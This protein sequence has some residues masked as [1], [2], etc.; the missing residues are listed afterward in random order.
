[1]RRLAVV[2]LA[3]A[4]VGAKDPRRLRR[5]S[6]INNEAWKQGEPHT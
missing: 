2:A 1:M 5:Q 3:V 4:A 6:L